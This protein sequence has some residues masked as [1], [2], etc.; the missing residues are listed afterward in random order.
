MLR[1]SLQFHATNIIF[2]IFLFLIVGT[3]CMDISARPKMVKIDDFKFLSGKSIQKNSIGTAEAQVM[4][5]FPVG[6]L[7]RDSNIFIF[8]VTCGDSAHQFIRDIIPRIKNGESFL[9]ANMLRHD[10]D[11]NIWT[12]IFK[13]KAEYR[14][15]LVLRLYKEILAHNGLGIGETHK[16]ID[17][18]LSSVPLEQVYSGYSLEQASAS[19]IMTSAALRE[20]YSVNATPVLTRIK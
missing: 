3:P 20:I 10:A 13:L 16:M 6:T 12:R 18:Y 5:T 4:S 8:S 11:L 14:M 15:V 17:K 2:W 1:Y 7:T 9:L 19:G